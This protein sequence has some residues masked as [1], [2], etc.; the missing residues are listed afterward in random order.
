[1]TEYNYYEAV[2]DDVKQY[3]EDN[4]LGFALGAFNNDFDMIE[5]IEN[6]VW[7]EDSVTG[8]ASGSYT[9]NAWQAE[10]NLSHNWELIQEMSNEFG[11]DLSN[12][13]ATPEYLDVSLR[14]YVLVPAIEEALMELG[15]IH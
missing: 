7:A 6:E 4:G 2:K 13:K 3:I 1:M 5:Y 8:N 14:C 11:V 12:P 15:Y 9:F 10:E